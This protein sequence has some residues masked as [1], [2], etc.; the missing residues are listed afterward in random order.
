MD[1][2][3]IAVDFNLFGLEEAFY[4]R[5]TVSSSSSDTGS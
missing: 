5:F 4:L 3:A 2:Q 1:N